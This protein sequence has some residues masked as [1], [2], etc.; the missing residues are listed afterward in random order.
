MQLKLLRDQVS[1]GFAVH[2][3]THSHSIGLLYILLFLHTL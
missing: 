3:K 1:V 2:D